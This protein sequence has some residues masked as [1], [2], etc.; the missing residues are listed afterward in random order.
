MRHSVALRGIRFPREDD[1]LEYFGYSLIYFT[2][3]PINNGIREQTKQGMFRSP[4]GAIAPDGSSCV[5]IFKKRII[6][7]AM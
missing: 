6:G 4:V 3:T 2:D 5:S 1:A 7:T